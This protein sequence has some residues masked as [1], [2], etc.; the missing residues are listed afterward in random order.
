[1]DT[2]I[3]LLDAAIYLFP[4][5]AGVGLAALITFRSLARAA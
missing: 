5:S 1:M 4:I 2:L 3:T